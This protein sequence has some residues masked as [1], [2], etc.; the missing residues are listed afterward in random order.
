MKIILEFKH[1][2]V[3]DIRVD[4]IED[5]IKAL[6]L[7][8]EEIDRNNVVLYWEKKNIYVRKMKPKDTY[9]ILFGDGN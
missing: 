5:V 4:Y 9:K 2:N 7:E 8:K 1:K 6:L 3:N